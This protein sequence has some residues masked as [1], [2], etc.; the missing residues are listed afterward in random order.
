MV[1]V[2]NSISFFFPPSAAD[3]NTL[4]LN[5]VPSGTMFPVMVKVTVPLSEWYSVPVVAS[6]ASYGVSPVIDP[7]GRVHQRLAPMTTGV[8]VG[9]LARRTDLTFFTRVGWL[10][11]WATLAPATAW[12]TVHLGI[13]LAARPVRRAACGNGARCVW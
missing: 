4:N 6:A 8:L 10:F 1:T 2:S 3:T 13:H 7:H 9:R 12:L 11:P 5:S